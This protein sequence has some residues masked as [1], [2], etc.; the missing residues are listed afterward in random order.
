MSKICETDVFDN[1]IILGLL[2]YLVAT[3]T[4]AMHTDALAVLAT[5]W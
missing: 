5:M 3:D 2:Q 1:P 4:T